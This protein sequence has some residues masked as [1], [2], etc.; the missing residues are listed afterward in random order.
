MKQSKVVQLKECE[1]CKE[2]LEIVQVKDGLVARE[3]ASG[4]VHVC[5]D[6]PKDST[7]LVMND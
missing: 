5:W 7:L 2:S 4:E 3:V 1:H 6:L